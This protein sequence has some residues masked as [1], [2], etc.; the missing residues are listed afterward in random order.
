MP[1]DRNHILR[2]RKSARRGNPL[3]EPQCDFVLLGLAQQLIPFVAGGKPSGFLA[4]FFDLIAQAIYVRDFVQ[5]RMLRFD[6][7]P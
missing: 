1:S 5:D 4:K 6:C 2:G 7:D 3:D